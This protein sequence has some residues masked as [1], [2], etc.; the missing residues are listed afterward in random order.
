MKSA[1][2]SS[3]LAP[4]A[5]GSAFGAVG[6]AF[7]AVTQP[8]AGRTPAKLSTRERAS[9]TGQPPRNARLP[10]SVPHSPP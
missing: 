2:G 5:V 10:T 6:S 9:A 4:L 1:V 7:G 3:G 8:R